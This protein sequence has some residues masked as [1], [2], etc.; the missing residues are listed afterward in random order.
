MEEHHGAPSPFSSKTGFVAGIIVG[1]LALSTIGFFI[2]LGVVLKGGGIG[3]LSASSASPA[4]A[5]APSPLPGPSLAP[6]PSPENIVVKAVSKDDHVRGDR[7]AKI[8]VIEFSDTECPF[9]KRFHP[10]MQQIVEQNKG[11]VNWVYRHFPLRSLHKKAAKEAEATECAAELGGNEVFWKYVDRLFEVTPS[12]DGLDASELPNIAETVGLNRAK[13][14]TCLASGKYASKVAD[15][16][17]QAT[18]AG[19]QGTPHSIVLGLNGEKEA[20]YGAVSASEIQSIID[21]MIAS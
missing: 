21:R 5:A 13:F 7:K 14:E 6:P 16:E 15:Q 12:N 2:L 19:A 4:V 20:V 11:A 9:C 10:T 1:I 8:S 3:A 18:A 17:Q